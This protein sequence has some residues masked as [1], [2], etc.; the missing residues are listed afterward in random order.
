VLYKISPQ[1]SAEL[2]AHNLP[3]DPKAAFRNS[4]GDLFLNTPEGIYRI[5]QPTPGERV[6]LVMADL[7][8][9]GSFGIL[10]DNR[11]NT[12]HTHLENAVTS[13]NRGKSGAAENHL[14]TFLRSLISYMREGILSEEHAD[15]F[16]LATE[17]ILERL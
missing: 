11:V 9:L 17:D 2:F 16:I 15:N 8:R 3:V 4:E 7:A 1:G 12:L 14:R 5:W 10:D 13:L 6:Q